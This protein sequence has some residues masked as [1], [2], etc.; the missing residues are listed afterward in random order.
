MELALWGCS[1][2]IALAFLVVGVFLLMA[3]LDVSPAVGH[4]VPLIL[5]VAGA[6]VVRYVKKLK[7]NSTWVPEENSAPSAPHASAASRRDNEELKAV[8]EAVVIILVLL[9]IAAFV[10]WR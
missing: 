2:Y 8:M 7:K 3:A 5:L 4:S 1:S 9:G 6:F 10:F